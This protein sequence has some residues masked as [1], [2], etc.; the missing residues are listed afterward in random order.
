MD[1]LERYGTRIDYYD[2]YIGYFGHMVPLVSGRTQRKD[3]YSLALETA[4]RLADNFWLR[5]NLAYDMGE[6]YED[7]FGAQAAVMF[8]F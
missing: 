8:R 1:L 7:R 2:S 4:S 6:L 5:L 3:Q